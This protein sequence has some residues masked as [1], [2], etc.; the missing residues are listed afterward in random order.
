MVSGAAYVPARG[1]VVWITL[2]PQAGHE[3]AGR[4]P[5]VVL[6]PRSYNRK[7]GLAILCPITSHVKGYPFEV[8]IPSGLP[9]RGVILAD[10]VKSLDWRASEAEL[11]CEL[12]G[13]TMAEVL[14]KIGVLLR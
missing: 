6:S 4:R 9:V 1:D 12:P 2:N 5:A 8:Q 7:V 13:A 10:Q 3:Q 11:M 14:Q